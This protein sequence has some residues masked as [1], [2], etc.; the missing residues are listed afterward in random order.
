ML[1]KLNRKELSE[2]VLADRGYYRSSLLRRA[3]AIATGL[4]PGWGP[5]L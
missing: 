4:F 3:G 1:D 5:K 2:N